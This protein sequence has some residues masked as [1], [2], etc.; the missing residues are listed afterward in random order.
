MASFLL[1]G[2]SSPG[3]TGNYPTSTK[4]RNRSG[5]LFPGA[6]A[7]CSVKLLTLSPTQ[8]ISYVIVSI[9]YG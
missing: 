9:F 4:F 2:C 3:H 1:A 6:P 5:T 8:H 7:Y